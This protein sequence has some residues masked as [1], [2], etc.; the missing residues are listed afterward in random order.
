MPFNVAL[1]GF[2]VHNS[3]KANFISKVYKVDSAQFTEVLT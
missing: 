1:S 3:I 2:Q